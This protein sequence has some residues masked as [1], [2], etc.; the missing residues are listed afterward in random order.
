M[1]STHPILLS[2]FGSV[3][4]AADLWATHYSGT[5]N[6]LTF[7]EGTL[8]LG[9]STPTGNRLP[10]WITYDGPGKALYIPDE[11]F[12]GA[13]GGNLVSFS[14]GNNGTLTAAGKAPTPLGAV[15]TT[16]Y[17]GADGRGFIA[18][19]HYQSSQ[20]TTFKLPLNGGQP[21]QTLKY[22]MS[23][24]GVDPNRQDVPH[25]H[26]AF[27]DPTGNFL[28]VPDL[29]ADLIRINK[30]DKTSGQLTECPS[31]KP[32]PGSGPRHG[33]FWNPA[34][35]NSRVRRG[36]EGT[37][38]F[39]ANELT[40][41]V[42]GWSVSY[43]SGGCLALT[44][45]QNVTPY[46]GNSSAA[47]SA[48]VGEIK[49][50]GNFLYITNRNDKKF[51]PNDSL[52]QYT[53]SSDGTLA[54][55]D[56][57]SSYGTYPR[58]FDINKAG[59]FVAIGDQTTANVAI[60]SRDPVTGKLGERVAD[61]RVGAVGTPGNEDG[62]S[63]VPLSK[64]LNPIFLNLHHTKINKMKSDNYLNLCLEQAAKSPLRYRHGAII[65]RGGKVIGQGFN[66]HRSGFD[67]GA[68]KTGR[69]PLRSMNGPAI[70]ALKGKQKLKRE[71]GV[72]GEE[73]AKTFTPFE[74]MN[75]GGKL[76]NTP[77][78]MHSEMMAIHSA[79]SASSTM[80]SSILSSQKPC[81]KL[82]GDSKRKARLR[83]DAVKSYVEAVCKAAL[84]HGALKALHLDRTTLNLAHQTK[85]V[86]LSTK[87]SAVKHR[88]KNEKKNQHR[89]GN[90]S[91]SGQQK[92]K[93]RQCAHKTMAST[94]K[95][96]PSY[97]TKNQSAKSSKAQPMLIP[98]GQTG[99]GSRKTKERTKHP[100][101]NG[102][103][104]YVVRQGWKASS[105]VSNLVDC[106]AEPNPKV[107]TSITKL[108]STGSLYDELISSQVET[109]LVVAPSVPPERHPSVLASR[110]CY[111]CISYMAS[112][113]IKRAFWTT[114]SGDWEGAKVR[115]LVDALDNLGL[116]QPSG[117]T[118]A[119]NSVFVTKHEVLMLRRIMGDT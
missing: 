18:N 55:T 112:V 7:S 11:V 42:H 78:S 99:E 21:L 40:N 46:Q 80:T 48:K 65:V 117:A 50:K 108:P 62:I 106:C 83:R 2:L 17:G 36:A 87:N 61:V 63:A 15:A 113:G 60:V 22:T 9:S 31:A 34:G 86:A 23:G 3:A 101:L 47:A 115:D 103:D 4:S 29:G 93:H 1:L 91:N 59:D 75:S 119:L 53:I 38:L 114:E 66:D 52:T 6:H 45:K 58:T 19:A 111:R 72:L 57:T 56:N 51:A 30:I 95:L 116:E 8:K 81:F 92:H 39:V 12:Y 41:S 89:V 107:E 32:V 109:N 43:P 35:T 74:T 76:A 27:V 71:L 5:V 10:S 14:I 44:L 84:A 82:S 73:T 104:L 110:P 37:I 26:H 54:W 16:L 49:V 20:L 105:S 13:P 96:R 118:T 28:L 100:R 67:G 77:L 97:E 69:L 24:K 70:V 33:V 64:V 85:D 94:Y 88:P 25:P 79:L 90:K 102:A 68:L 98:K